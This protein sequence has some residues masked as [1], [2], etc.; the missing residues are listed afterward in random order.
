MKTSEY[1]RFCKDEVKR[2]SKW[3]DKEELDDLWKRMVDLYRGRHYEGKSGNDR[4]I[5]NLAFATKNVIAPSVAINN[6]MFVVNARKI[7]NA[8]N[9]ILTEEIL[10]YLWRVHKYQA[11][12][13]LAVDD[14][15]VLGHGWVKCGYKFV[16]PPEEKKA[17]L[18]D[19]EPDTAA[20]EGIDDREDMD[21]NVESELHVYD[22]R[23]FIER[24]SPFDMYVDPD[25]RHPKE[26]RWI[27]QRTWRVVQDVRVDE[28]YSSVAR[29]RVAT[30]SYSRW[31]DQ[32]DG[33]DADNLPDKGAMGFCEI[34]EF[35]DLKRNTVATFSLKN[36]DAA[37]GD[38]FL[39]KPRPIPFS[40]GCPFVMLRNYEIPDNFYPMG[41][42][43]SIESL[44]LELNATRT[45]MLNHRKRFSRKWVYE[46]DAFDAEGVKALESDVD[47]V[48]VPVISDRSPSEVL[49]PLP[50]VLTPTDFYNQSELISSDIDRVSGVSDY[51]RGAQTEI[52]RTA[53]E[54]GMIQDAANARAQDKLAKIENVLAE[55]ASRIVALMQQFLTGE[56]A[57]R[58]VTMGGA[59]V[60]VNYDKDYL[61]GDFDFEVEG[62]STEPQNESFR[63][64]SALQMVDAMAPFVGAGVV[65]PA[66]LAQYVLQ[67]GFGIKN[68]G[69][70]MATPQT[71]PGGA[72]GAPPG[73]PPGAE[74]MPPEQQQMPP[75]G[76]P[77][78]GMPQGMPPEMGMP[79]GMPPMGG[80][81]Q[82]GMPPDPFAA[83][84][85]IPPE[86]MQMLMQMQG[87]GGG[88][89]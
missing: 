31:T 23:P 85:E 6:P 69:P 43:E 34:I 17:S 2:S 57:A 1:L 50:A 89:Q 26:M 64:Q 70:F 22:D 10:N 36:S 27:A 38:L 62:G 81:P 44:Q 15:L 84:G 46:K 48:L 55:V 3:R 42:L 79:P 71:P 18:D 63:R 86:L 37:T 5:V 65:N 80:A 16:K 40:F 11:E 28:R 45:Q 32:Q 67:H 68:T 24:V 54:A 12:F 76:M 88:P 13:R 29:K 61:A 83:G 60:W 87:S 77:P 51:Q 20:D 14:W 33:R 21:G 7:E 82:G 19:V 47:N 53:T 75:E 8:E 73:A 4:L 49:A 9:A 58:I 74:Q 66:V 30:S 39:I 41:E 59:R 78:E 35:Y 56:H 25:A 52:R 72:Q